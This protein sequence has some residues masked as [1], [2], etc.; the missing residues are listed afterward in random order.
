MDY[1]NAVRMAD[2]AFSGND[3]LT[4]KH[5]YEAALRAKPAEKYP[6]EKIDACDKKMASSSWIAERLNCPCT[7]GKAVPLKN[8]TDIYTISS[9]DSIVYAVLPG[10]VSSVVLDSNSHR[11]TV[12][13]K[14]GKYVATYAE[15]KSTPL[16]NNDEV[17][18]GQDIGM[19]S[20][21]NGTYSFNFSLLQGKEKESAMS[22][23]HCK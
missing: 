2:L 20:K 1:D 15:L 14:H 22:L 12:V 6:Q 17:K 8:F 23:V 10:S 13:V 4:A 9:D 19:L 21:Q 5:F 7:K 18:E 11:Y 3:Y 16:K